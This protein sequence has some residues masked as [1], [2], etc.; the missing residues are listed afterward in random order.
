MYNGWVNPHWADAA[1]ATL[2]NHRLTT[3]PDRQ[4]TMKYAGLYITLSVFALLGP[5][6]AMS[7]H[8]KYKQ[9]YPQYGPY[10]ADYMTYNCTAAYQ[11]YLSPENP[12]PG[13]LSCKESPVVNCLL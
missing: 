3:L 9:W 11:I 5:R 2:V 10:F 12:W 7:S 6:F 8:T 13:C 1:S 4:A